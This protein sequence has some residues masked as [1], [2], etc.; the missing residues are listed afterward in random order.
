MYNLSCATLKNV[1]CFHYNL[2]EYRFSIIIQIYIYMVLEP[3]TQPSPTGE[4]VSKYLFPL[5]GNKKGGKINL[6][7]EIVI[8]S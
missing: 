3:P 6:F 8:Y 4:G 2:N 7:E 1:K 5:G